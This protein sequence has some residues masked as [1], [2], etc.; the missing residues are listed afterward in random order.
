MEK[1]V[2]PQQFIENV[3]QGL[4]GIP[5]MHC[6]RNPSRG[7]DCLGLVLEFYRRLGLPLSDP[8]SSY[9][10][11]WW[12]DAPDLIGLHIGSYFDRVDMPFP[13]SVIT[14]KTINGTLPIQNV[15]QNNK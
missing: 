15:Q 7:L 10:R 13:G 6:G 8:V 4:I 1:V 12:K 3:A 2:L 11:E 9:D 14:V 5:F